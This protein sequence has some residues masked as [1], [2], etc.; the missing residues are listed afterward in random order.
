MSLKARQTLAASIQNVS[1]FAHSSVRRFVGCWASKYSFFGFVCAILLVS[2][3]TLI[4][5]FICG[6]IFQTICL[7][8]I[9]SFSKRKLNTQLSLEFSAKINFSLHLWAKEKP[10]RYIFCTRFHTHKHTLIYTPVHS[11]YIYLVVVF[12]RFSY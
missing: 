9:Y 6:R 8:S 5:H 10:M 1:H 7:T 2:S 11:T 3:K 12:I 4:S